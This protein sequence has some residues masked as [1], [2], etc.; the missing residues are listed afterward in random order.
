MACGDAATRELDALLEEGLE[1]DL[2][3]GA[4]AGV[5]TSAGRF[6]AT[7]G[8]HARDDPTPIGLASVFDLASVSKTFT[9]AIVVRLAERGVVDLDA[10]VA[11]LLPVGRGSGAERITLRMLL[12]HVSGL[13]AESFLWRDSDVSPGERLARVLATPL[14]SVPDAV[15]RY[16]C[17]GYIAAGAVVERATGSPLPELL[18]EFVTAPLGIGS[19]GYGPV[20]RSVA[21]ATED[22]PWVGRGV[23]RGEVHDELNWF[24]GGQVGNA[25]LFGTADDVLTFAASFL[26]SGFLG[27]EA[28]RSMTTDALEPRHGAGYG[29][30]VGPRVR[31]QEF[32]GSVDGFGHVGFTGTMWFVAPDP[33]VAAVLLTNRVHPHRDRVDLDPFRRRFSAWAVSV[34]ERPRASRDSP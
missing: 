2:Y 7:A 9:A 28:L 12:T 23:V 30:A 33:G 15:H 13:P 29:Q 6:V 18:D 26:D 1:Q 34:A 5:V 4:A 8:S 11:P 10:P 17:L 19:V 24:L 31:D 20:D 22:E 16:S 3:S 14:E 21:V 25:G 27:A 32:L